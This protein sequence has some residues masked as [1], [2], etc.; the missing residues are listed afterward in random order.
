Q[1]GGFEDVGALEGVGENSARTV[2]VEPLEASLI[3]GDG[4]GRGGNGSGV[5]ELADGSGGVEQTEAA[6]AVQEVASGPGGG[7]AEGGA[8][9]EDTALPLVADANRGALVDGD[10]LL[11]TGIAQRAV[12]G[13]TGV[14]GAEA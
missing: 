9:E 3:V 4:N 6:V 8:V 5:E 12:E 14:H 11:A 2:Q 13:G 10:L 7:E 1:P